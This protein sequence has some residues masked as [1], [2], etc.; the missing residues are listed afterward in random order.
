LKTGVPDEYWWEDWKND[1]KQLGDY[2]VMKPSG[3]ALGTTTAEDRAI[4]D[5]GFNFSFPLDSE[6]ARYVRFVV[7][8][9]FSNT[10][11]LHI[12]GITIFGSD[13]LDD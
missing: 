9:T 7:K 11:A 4:A 3:S 10:L 1:W 12:A 6:Q 2:E 5:A 8:Q 13:G